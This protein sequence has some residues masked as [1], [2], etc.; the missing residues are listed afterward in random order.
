MS[1]LSLNNKYINSELEMELKDR[2]ISFIRENL[3]HC[4]VIVNG[5]FRCILYDESTID[6]SLI[7]KVCEKYEKDGIKLIFV[8]LKSCSSNYF[9]TVYLYEYK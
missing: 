1:V 9:L 4:D 8:N 2:Q 7:P 6:E 5:V 3:S